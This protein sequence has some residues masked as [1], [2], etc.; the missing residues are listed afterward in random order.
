[1]ELPARGIAGLID[2]SAVQT[3]HGTN[4]IKELVKY[5]KE[6]KFVAIHVLPCWVTFLKEIITERDKIIIGSPAGLPSGGH[7]TKVKVLEVK[8][9][10]LDG[11]QEVDMMM[12]VGM[13]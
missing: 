2:I 9:M 7:K 10:L 12:N 1:M 11:V 6:Y 3:P 13:L 5:A 8:Q 4:E